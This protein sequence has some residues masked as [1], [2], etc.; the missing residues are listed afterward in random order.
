MVSKTSDLILGSD[1]KDSELIATIAWI[2]FFS[3]FSLLIAFDNVARQIIKKNIEF[4]NKTLFEKGFELFVNRNNNNTENHN[5]IINIKAHPSVE[6]KLRTRL[7]KTQRLQRSTKTH[8]SLHSFYI[9][10]KFLLSSLYVYL[11]LFLLL[12]FISF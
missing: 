10:S 9:F 4:K 5:E 3:N 11:D 8:Q 6:V 1:L 12:M 2:E 7:K